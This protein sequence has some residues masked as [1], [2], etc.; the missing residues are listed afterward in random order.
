MTNIL[1]SERDILYSQW[2]MGIDKSLG[3]EPVSETSGN[4]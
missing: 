3:W 2:K 4:Y 1:I